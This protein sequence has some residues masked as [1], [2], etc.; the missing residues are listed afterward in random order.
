LPLITWLWGPEI[1]PDPEALA[2]GEPL[3]LSLTLGFSLAAAGLQALAFGLGVGVVMW[4]RKI[5]NTAV[6]LRPL[7]QTWW[8]YA[9]VL[10][11][12][13]IPLTGYLAYGFQLLFYDEVVNP[14]LDFVVPEG[15]SWQAIIGMTLLVGF[16]I[17]FVEEL[18][19]RG[20]LF[21]WWRQKWSFWP[22]ALLSS[23]L[24]ALLHGELSLMVGTFA[25]GLLAVWAVEKSGS[26]W[27][28][29]WIH[30]LNNG[31]KVL[32]IYIALLM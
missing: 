18:F 20:V 7:S 28:A 30:V 31:V 5:P 8:Q 11:F 23:A 3:D 2:G 15:F 10:G 26:L 6:Y 1:A 24:F 17:P 25:L 12:I 4:V 16:A 32:V 27:A 14:Q 9:T 13:C 21:G 19:F 22:A 29:I